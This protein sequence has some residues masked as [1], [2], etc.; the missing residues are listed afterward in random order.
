MGAHKPGPDPGDAGVRGLDD[1]PHF[2][3][4]AV[5]WPAGPGAALTACLD[6]LVD[7]VVINSAIRDETG[8][9]VD[10]RVV[11]ANE[12]ASRISGVAHD[13][14]VG[15][16][17]LDLFPGRRE[18]GQFDAYVRVVETGEPLIR[19]S[20]RDHDVADRS[21][22]EGFGRDFEVSVTR[23]TSPAPSGSTR[24]PATTWRPR[25]SSPTEGS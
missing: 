19:N 7:G 16:R 3:G 15:Y 22:P 23:S 10:F 21:D 11:Y 13:D 8:R 14:L 1:G 18:N 4:D 20:E 9:I 6:G 2:S 25:S 24:A 17:I 5:S 12:A